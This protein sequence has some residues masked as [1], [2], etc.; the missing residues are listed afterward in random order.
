MYQGAGQ[1][2]SIVQVPTALSLGTPHNP[3]EAWRVA[4]L[5]AAG[6]VD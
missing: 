3:V 6:A 1:P 4:D 5:H 2:Y